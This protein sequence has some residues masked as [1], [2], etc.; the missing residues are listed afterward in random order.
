MAVL[1]F[2][3]GLEALN[4]VAMFNN[5]VLNDRQ[6]T[7]RFDTKP[8]RDE[9][10]SSK[11]SSSSKL[12]SK[13]FDIYFKENLISGYLFFNSFKNFVQSRLKSVLSE[14]VIEFVSLKCKIFVLTKNKIYR[15]S[16]IKKKHF[17]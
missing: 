3:S 13:L 4:A 12:P 7:V 6:M 2:D 14:T 1:E 11:G 9:E 16:C 5:Q 17:L 10:T 15:L 8:P